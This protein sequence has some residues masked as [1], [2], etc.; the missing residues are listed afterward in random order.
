MKKSK[1]L[2]SLAASVMLICGPF[3]STASAININD[4]SGLEKTIKQAMTKVNSSL[5]ITYTG[6]DADFIYRN[7]TSISMSIGSRNDDILG[8]LKSVSTSSSLKTMN[9]K[10]ISATLNLQINYFTTKAKKQQA[11][12]QLKKVA[13]TIKKNNKTDFARVQAVNEYLVLNTTYG[14][15]KEDRYTTYGLLTDKQAVCQGYATAAYT[16]LKTMGMDVRYVVGIGYNR[17]GGSEEHAWNKVKVD[18]KWYNLD[19]TWNDPVPNREH[20]VSYQ[21]FLLSDKVFNQDH[22]AKNAS[23][24]PAATD[25]KYDFLKNTSSAV[26]NGHII[27]YANDKQKQQLYSYD[28]K[29]RKHKR[30]AAVRVQYLAYDHKKLYFSNYSNA[31]YLASMNTNGK[32]LKIL[33]KKFS[34]NLYV[35]GKK[36]YYVA[37][38][39]T[40]SKSIK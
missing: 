36:L 23:L 33:D 7:I 10:P 13:A 38:G 19:V 29:Q 3:A 5:Q 25:T 35:Q 2:T 8:V 28:M 32:S 17:S 14:G 30:V 18:G 1:W 40:Y 34:T 20:T 27:Y 9:G 21:Y 16:L 37:N 31:G 12:A 6:S 39:K 15:T 22:V 26:I 4:K 11:D 24:Y